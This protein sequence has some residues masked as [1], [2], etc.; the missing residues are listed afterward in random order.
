[1][2][3]SLPVL[4]QQKYSNSHFPIQFYNNC[5]EDLMEVLIKRL[6]TL[7]LIKFYATGLI[8]YSLK[9]LKKNRD[10]DQKYEQRPKT[11]G[12]K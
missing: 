10:R 12:M 3:D 11:K 8:P 7:Q 5:S 9:K 6:E 4:I 2:A 1:M